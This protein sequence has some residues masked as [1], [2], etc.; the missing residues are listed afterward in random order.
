MPHATT[1]SEGHA[2]TMQKAARRMPLSKV[3]L[4]ALARGRQF[5]ALLD[6][7]EAEN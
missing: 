5:E 3:A 2:A 6:L 4:D 1:Y 7:G